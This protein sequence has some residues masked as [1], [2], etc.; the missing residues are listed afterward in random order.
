MAHNNTLHVCNDMI[1]Y[2]IASYYLIDIPDHTGNTTIYRFFYFSRCTRTTALVTT[3]FHL[4]DVYVFVLETGLHVLV[5]SRYQG[6]AHEGQPKNRS[7]G[8]CLFGRSYSP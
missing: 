4:L 3:S 1:H 2:T 5:S 6:N 7:G 8:M